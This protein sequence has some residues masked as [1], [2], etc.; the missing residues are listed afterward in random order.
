MSF[1]T[2]LRTQVRAALAASDRLGIVEFYD[3]FPRNHDAEKL[4]YC[5]VRTPRERT[6]RDHDFGVN[7]ATEVVVSY[8]RVGGNDLEDELDLDADEVVEVVLPVLRGVGLLYGLDLT[9]IDV[10]AAGE[11][12][13]GELDMTFTVER[14][15]DED[16]V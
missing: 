14:L 4:P 2:I 1:R 3:A 11:T 7:R 10:V 5:I 13:R 16:E 15:L 9:E 8:R 12:R 6:N